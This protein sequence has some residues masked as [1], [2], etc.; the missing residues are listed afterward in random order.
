MRTCEIFRSLQG[1]GVLMGAPTTFVRTVGCNLDCCWCDTPYAKQGGKERSVDE[2]LREVDAH[3]I[4]MVCVT[5]GEPL[6]QKEIYGL[7]EALIARRYHVTLETNGSLPLDELPCTESLMISM[8]LKCPSSGMCDRMVMDNLEILSPYDQ[9]KFVVDGRED[10]DYVLEVINTYEINCPVIV[11][12]VGGREL[13]PLAEWALANRVRVR[14]LPQLH[15][16]IW[17]EGR[18]V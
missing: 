2:I 16:I 14:V 12:P 4:P 1:E 13:R 6:L 3:G 7:L 11:T 15:K 9:L 8:D 10:M 18:G 17:G 5:G